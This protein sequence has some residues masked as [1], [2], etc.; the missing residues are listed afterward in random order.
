MFIIL[1]GKPIWKKATMDDPIF[2]FAYVS[3][4]RN[5]LQQWKQDLVLGEDGTDLIC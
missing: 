4:M 1:T 5:L 2:K 3:G